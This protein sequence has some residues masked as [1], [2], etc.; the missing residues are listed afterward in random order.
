[1]LALLNK[2]KE[3]KQVV[4]NGSGAE[5]LL[6]FSLRLICDKHQNFVLGLFNFL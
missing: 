6:Q 5:D 2:L 4:A 1:M 3:D